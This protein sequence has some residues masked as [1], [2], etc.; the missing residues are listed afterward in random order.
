MDN[1]NYPEGSDT[2][3]APWNQ[4]DLVQDRHTEQAESELS[5][6]L[7]WGSDAGIMYGDLHA[8]IEGVVSRSFWDSN[9][10]LVM[11][12]M[13][14]TYEDKG[15]PAMLTIMPSYYHRQLVGFAEDHVPDLAVQFAEDEDP[16]EYHELV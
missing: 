9:F 2:P 3:D 12:Q 6:L 14:I 16:W 10:S 4:S 8:M 13:E 5:P 15:T 1:Y 7:E 11:E